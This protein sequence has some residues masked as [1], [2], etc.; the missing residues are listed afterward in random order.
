MTGATYGMGSS[1]TGISPTGTGVGEAIGN[2]VGVGEAITSDADIILGRK[3]VVSESP[4]GRMEESP[5]PTS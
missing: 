5:D 3:V 2:D 1:K 4:G